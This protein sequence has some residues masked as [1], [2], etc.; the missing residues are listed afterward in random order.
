MNEAGVQ[1][2][3]TRPGALSGGATLAALG[4]ILSVGLAARLDQLG[5]R[6]FAFDEAWSWRVIGFPVDDMFARLG[7]DVHPP[8]FYCFLRAWAAVFGTSPAALRCFSVFFGLVTIVGTYVFTSEAF[9][10]RAPDGRRTCKARGLGLFAAALIALSA[11]QIR[12]SWEARMYTLGTALAVFSGWALVRA[13]RTDK[14]W[15]WLVYATLA[16]GFVYTHYFAF[17]ALAAQGL[18]ASGYLWVRVGGRLTRLWGERSFRY[19]LLACFGVAIGYLPWIP[20]F[21]RQKSQ[22]DDEYWIRS[23]E[24][25]DIPLACHHM[26]F[27][28]MNPQAEL[29][30]CI[31][32]AVVCA[33]A[34]GTLLWRAGVGHWYTFLTAVTPFA[35]CTV[36]ALLGTQIFSTR[37]F[38]FAHVFMLVAI[39]VLIWRIPILSARATVGVIV[40]AY[41]A[42]A[43]VRFTN[44]LEIDRRP[45]AKAAGEYIAKNRDPA[46]PVI[47]CSTVCYH[48]L[49][50]H[51]GGDPAGWKLCLVSG[52]L[53]HYNGGP[54][55]EP[56]ELFPAEGVDTLSGHRVWIIH[57]EGADTL[58]PP[59]EWVLKSERRFPGVIRE[60]GTVVVREY[61]R[62]HDESRLP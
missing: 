50:Y 15:W 6:S 19:A 21:V 13:L 48:A 52:K 24:A 9:D 46:E 23:M 60:Q 55:I 20:A 62:H 12:Y 39:A 8:L 25:S 27:E 4:L 30:D 42:F 7:R 41:F 38:I 47:V 31:P 10:R 59:A 14:P 40:L 35:G 3:S 44:D 28:P 32:I 18:F 1:E 57:R 2:S 49:I 54:L 45:G 22:V 61:V 29:A 43:H 36:L 53:T 26:F 56:D 11:M 16:L 17:F 51:S 58:T 37:Y 5:D 34:L 33:L